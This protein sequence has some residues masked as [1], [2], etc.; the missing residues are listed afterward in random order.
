MSALGRALRSGAVLAIAALAVPAAA[1]VRSSDRSTGKDLF[2]PVPLVP[3]RVSDTQLSAQSPTCAAGAGGDPALEAVTASFS[4]WRDACAD[5]ELLFAGEIADTHTGVGGSREN[6]VV[7]RKGWCSTIPDAAACMASGAEG[8]GN[9]YDCFEDQT[10]QDRS[11]VALTSALYD[12]DTGR[13]VNADIE[14]NAW[15]GQASGTSLSGGLSGPPHGWYFTCDKQG[16][17]P[18]CTTYGQTGCYYI[19]LQ[20]TV[21]HEVGHFIGLAH[22]CG[23]PGLPACSSD[24]AY[25]ETTMYPQTTPGDVAKRTLA[26]DDV[27]GFCAIYPASGGCGCGA[28]GAPGAIAAVLALLALR[29]RRRAGA[30]GR[31]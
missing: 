3:Y 23:D 18:L 24:P 16:G 29:P 8:C 30:R 11:I 28:G 26:P 25:A 9:T 4:T 15:D 20:N 10:P 1:Y 17:W 22:P 12:P 13:I 27:A 31:R 2:W 6:L 19:D 7:F 5:L 21:T 14:V